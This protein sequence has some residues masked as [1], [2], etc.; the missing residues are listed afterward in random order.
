MAQVKM[1]K[2]QI[3]IPEYL[4]EQYKLHEG[5]SILLVPTETGIVIKRECEMRSL[6]GSIVEIDVKKASEFIRKLRSEW[7]LE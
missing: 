5:D 6:R 2:G 1:S 4:R 3:T 7:R